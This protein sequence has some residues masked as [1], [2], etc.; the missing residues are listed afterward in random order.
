MFHWLWAIYSFCQPVAYSR[1]CGSLVGCWFQQKAQR[2]SHLLCLRHLSSLVFISEMKYQDPDLMVYL[3]WTDKQKQ[4]RGHSVMLI[5]EKSDNHHTQM[6]N[7]GIPNFCGT[8]TWYFRF[9]CFCNSFQKTGESV[10]CRAVNSAQER[11]QDVWKTLQSLTQKR[12]EN[13]GSRKWMSKSAL[14]LYL[15]NWWKLYL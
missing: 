5:I 8:W 3:M 13:S 2:K 9:C 10:W 11:E 6:M 15:A 12:T 4:Q 1:A 14:P 7:R